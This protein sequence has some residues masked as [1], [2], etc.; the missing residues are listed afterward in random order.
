[1]NSSQYLHYPADYLHPLPT[2]LDVKKS[3]L[4]MLAQTCSSIGKDD[5]KPGFRTVPPKE[6]PPLVPISKEQRLPYICNWVAGHDYCGKRFN[7]SEELMQHLRSHTSTLS[8]SVASAG[9]LVHLGMSAPMSPNS[10]RRAYPTSLSPGLLSS[11]FHP[12][13][14]QLGNIGAPPTSHLPPLSAYYPQY[15]SLYGPRLGAAV[16]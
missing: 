2:S 7:S 10:L 12:Y 13:K 3:P 11:R 15:S 1:M 14:S 9:G 16:P 4:A 6:I 8:A 5:E